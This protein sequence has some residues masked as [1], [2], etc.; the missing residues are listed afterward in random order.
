MIH[1]LQNTV[2]KIFLIT[3]HERSVIQELIEARIIRKSFFLDRTSLFSDR[4]THVE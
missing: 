3:P 4:F 1:I 2:D